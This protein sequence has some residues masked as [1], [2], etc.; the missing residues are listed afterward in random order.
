[1]EESS[2]DTNHKQTQTP[3]TGH[4]LP[5]I[6]PGQ[7]SEQTCIGPMTWLINVLPKLTY[8][9]QRRLGSDLQAV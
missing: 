8:V 3:S 2:T 9:R 7:N 4:Q 5:V 1:M 6:G